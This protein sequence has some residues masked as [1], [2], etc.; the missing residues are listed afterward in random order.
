CA[1]GQTCCDTPKGSTP[2]S[3]CI[4]GG[5]TCPATSPK[6]G[7][8]WECDA[9]SQCGTGKVCCGD[10]TPKLRTGCT[11]EEVFPAKGTV[12]AATCSATQFTVCE[13]P[14]DCPSGKTCTAIKSGS[15][16]LGYCK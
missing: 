5:S 3:S 15:K 8:T 4:A 7:S 12:C 2:A 13:A 6:S 10:G 9:P 14:G 11:Y 16:N 1:I